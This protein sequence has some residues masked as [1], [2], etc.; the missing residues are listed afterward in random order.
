[1]LWKNFSM[2]FKPILK[3]TNHYLC[4]LEHAK[5]D[6]YFIEGLA[7]SPIILAINIFN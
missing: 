7:Y 3:F 5:T 2:T 6:H 1:M 4:A